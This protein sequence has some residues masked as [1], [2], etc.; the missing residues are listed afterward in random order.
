M[1]W[2]YLSMLGLN[3][4]HFSKRVHW[5][6]RC[7]AAKWEST[8]TGVDAPSLSL[9]GGSVV[10][11]RSLFPLCFPSFLT[12]WD[13]DVWPHAIFSNAFSPMKMYEVRRKF[14]WSLFLK[15]QL[16][17]LQHWFKWWLGATRA[18]SRYLNQWCLVYRRIYATV[19]LDKF[20]EPVIDGRFLWYD[21]HYK[22]L[23]HLLHA[24]CSV[25]H[26]I[27]LW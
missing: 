11:A 19:R 21:K 7:I 23:L 14:H 20:R 10:F 27:I 9:A 5:W 15:G 12:N 22:M 24:S 25:Y 2:N 26:T 1:G 4:Y 13:R 8:A 17:I 16:T 3:L 6:L 18:T